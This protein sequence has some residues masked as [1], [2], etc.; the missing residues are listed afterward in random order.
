M[1]KGFFG[2]AFVTVNFGILGFS[3]I[4]VFGLLKVVE[5][6]VV[7]VLRRAAADDDSVDEAVFDVVVAV[8]MSF[9][10]FVFGVGLDTVL[11]T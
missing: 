6:T 4:V 3:E 5:R 7:D 10:A 9:D 2:D 11:K 8:L 1:I